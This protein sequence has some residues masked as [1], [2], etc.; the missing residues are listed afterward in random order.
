M[1]AFIASEARKLA[2]RSDSLSA[3]ISAKGAELQS[4]A[5][6]GG[7]NVI[8]SGD[9]AFWSWH[10]PNLFPIVGA[11]AD[12]TLIHE[13]RRYTMK[14]HGFLRH[15]LCDVLVDDGLSA[16][17]RLTDS[18]E[19]RAVY[20]FAFELTIAYRL[21]G[22]RLDARFTL[23]NPAATALYASLGAH[24][25][26]CWPL[27]AGSRD[28]HIVR[29][30][31]AEPEPLRQLA[32]GLMMPD[33][34][35]TPVRGK[36]LTL[37]DDLFAE[38]ALIFDRLVSRELTYGAPGGPAVE[39]GFPDFPYL[40]IWSKPTPAPFVCL[41]PWQGLASPV[42]FRGEFRDK[43]GVVTLAPGETRDWRYWIR[44]LSRFPSPA[45][46]QA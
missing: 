22:D 16:V 32:N 21:S 17:F 19:T 40:G 30:E 25:A 13:G 29:F 42:D 7:D 12:D 4:L 23:A 18:D 15:S 20:P 33:S 36:V 28:A 1:T 43:P 44:P 11:L 38:D 10:A 24:P 27:G 37:R 31:H 45:D 3:T 39:V 6:A 34:R 46:D 2:L 9:A 35:T 26:F 8:W 14:Q 41:E 5:P